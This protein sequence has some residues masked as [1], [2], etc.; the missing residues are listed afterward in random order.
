MKTAIIHITITKI[1]S[2]DGWLFEYDRNKPFGPWPVNKDWL[3]RKRAG[4]KFWA[5]FERF[6]ELTEAEQDEC[7]V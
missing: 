3:P 2:F 5:M 4:R 1:Y 7:R 6:E